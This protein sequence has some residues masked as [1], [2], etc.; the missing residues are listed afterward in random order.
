MALIPAA[1]F[2]TLAITFTLLAAA[3]AASDWANR[4]LAPYQ[5][6]NR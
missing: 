2:L 1:A 4:N 5:Q 3:M 6:A